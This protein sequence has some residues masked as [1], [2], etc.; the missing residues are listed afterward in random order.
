MVDRWRMNTSQLMT[1][2][3]EKRYSDGRY[4]AANPAWHEEDAPFKAKYIDR[5]LRKNGIAFTSVA[6]IGCGTGGVLRNLRRLSVGSNASWAGFDISEDAI[7]RAQRDP[8]SD[9]IAFRTTDFFSLADDYDVLLVV[10]VFEHVPDYIGFVAACKNRARYKIYH[11]PLD[12][13]VL[14]ALRDSFL[15]VRTS[16]GHLHYFSERTALATLRDAGHRIVDKQ[17]TPGA[18][19]L[20][21]SHPSIKTAVANIARLA[22]GAVSVSM[23]ARL[24]GGY[25]LL[26][27]AE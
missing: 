8:G 11:I 27:L 3:L 1:S 15:N 5:I 19:E 24:L 23:S 16:V 18:L 14:A 20:F 25:S 7:S 10:D 12:L 17:L 21:K 4:L 22:V 9:G 6:E 2:E 13:H 26:V